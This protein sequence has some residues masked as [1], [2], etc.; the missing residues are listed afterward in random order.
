LIERDE[1]NGN[2]K[3]WRHLSALI[4]TR[5]FQVIYSTIRACWS[6]RLIHELDVV[7]GP[8]D[9]D[10]PPKDLSWHLATSFCLIL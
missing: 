10:R 6:K 9:P 4:C 1:V 2:W 5:S 3:F 7:Y 8:D